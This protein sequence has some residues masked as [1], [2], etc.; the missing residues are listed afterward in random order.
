M[1]PLLH[2]S[3]DAGFLTPHSEHFHGFCSLVMMPRIRVE[4]H[5][6]ERPICSLLAPIHRR[7]REQLSAQCV[8]CLRARADPNPKSVSRHLSPPPLGSRSRSSRPRPPSRGCHPRPTGR[9]RPGTDVGPATRAPRRV[10]RSLRTDSA[11]ARIGT[12]QERLFTRPLRAALATPAWSLRVWFMRLYSIWASLD[13]SQ[14]VG[15]SGLCI[16]DSS[17]V[18]K[19]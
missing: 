19:T 1:H 16:G 8:T 13:F 15:A 5:A 17:S 12:V 6:Q 3:R 18:T 4:I 10:L 7:V 14:E 2:V 11:A 9:G